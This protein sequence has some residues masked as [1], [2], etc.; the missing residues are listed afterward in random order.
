LI[1]DFSIGDVVKVIYIVF[2]KTKKKKK[3]FYNFIGLCINKKNYN[4]ILKNNFKGEKI[5][6]RFDLRS[7]VLVKLIVLKLY[8]KLSYRIS[9]FKFIK[10]INKY[11][12][13]YTSKDNILISSFNS[14]SFDYFHSAYL[15]K[16]LKRFKKKLRRFKKKYSYTENW[17]GL[18][19]HMFEKNS[20]Y[21]LD[22][23][24]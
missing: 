14:I 17:K 24:N 18:K 9:R 4:F 11:Y 7:P 8:L 2:L 16:K 10:K 13:D 22:D 20:I 12:D 15:K 19:L 6:I 1:K 21:L 5:T 3:K 23:Y